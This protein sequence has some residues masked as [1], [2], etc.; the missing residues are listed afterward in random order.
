[1]NATRLERHDLASGEPVVAADD[2]LRRRRRLARP[3]DARAAGGRVRQATGRRSCCST[4]RCRPTSTGSAPSAKATSAWTPRTRRPVV[5][6][7]AVAQRRARRF[8]VYDRVH[9]RGALPLPAPGRARGPAA[10]ADGAVLV[11]RPRRA[12]G[13]RLPD[14]PARRSSGASLPAVLDVHGGP[15]ARDTWGFDPEAQWLANRGYVCVQVNFRGSTGYGKAFLNAGDK[16]WGAAMQ[17]D[18]IGRRRARGRPGLGRPRPGGASTA[19][20]TAGTPCSPAPRSPRTCTAARVDIVGPSNLLTLLA[21][22]P[23]YWRPVIAMMYRRVG[24]PETE[25]GAAARAVAA[26][27]GREDPHPAARRPGRERPAGQAGRGR[28]D[29]GGAA[30]QGARRTSTCCSPTRATASPSREN[31]EVFYAARRGVPRRAPR[32]AACRRRRDPADRPADE[33]VEIVEVGPRDGLQNE[34]V[35][36]PT[37]AKVEFVRRA[38]AAGVRRIEVAS[39]VHPRLVPQMADAEAVV[40]GVLGGGFPEDVDREDVTLVG[41]VLNG[42]GLDRALAAGVDEV[43]VVIAASETFS[44]GTRTPPS[45][46][47]WPRPRTSRPGRRRQAS[48]AAPWCPRRSGAPSRAR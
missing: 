13:P 45:R 42:R 9:G 2:G 22:V 25:R 40:A 44:R 10:G 39:F 29:R 28:A 18:L 11:H 21:S 26:V 17:D 41:L 23:E 38:L 27:L 4:R 36:L 7:L 35:L 46:R 32:R 37:E 30:G 6:G 19:G 3:G 24:N 33:V 43:N 34:S 48:G 47:C 5:D 16:Q 8:C 15:W 31:R 12:H 14:V 20:R 1:M